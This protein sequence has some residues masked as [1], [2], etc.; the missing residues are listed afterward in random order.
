MVDHKSHY[1]GKMWIFTGLVT[2]FLLYLLI[3]IVIPFLLEGSI[4]TSNLARGIPICIVVGLLYGFI[5]KL[6]LVK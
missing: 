4:D 5:M 2:G 1:E 6:L 3:G